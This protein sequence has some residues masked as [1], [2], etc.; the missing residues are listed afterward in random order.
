M[1]INKVSIIKVLMSRYQY[2]LS[3]LITS[4]PVLYYIVEEDGSILYLVDFQQKALEVISDERRERLRV[5]EKEHTRREEEQE[6]KKMLAEQIAPP[7]SAEEEWLD[8]F[9]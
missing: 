9:Y 3:F 1:I 8:I 4:F 5:E 7:D 2:G 6:E